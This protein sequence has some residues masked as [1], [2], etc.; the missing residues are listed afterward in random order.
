MNV[1]ILPWLMKLVDFMP[2]IMDGYPFELAK[3]KN[4]SKIKASVKSCGGPFISGG[5][6]NAKSC[7]AYCEFYNYNANSPVIEGY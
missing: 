6:I 1:N 3:V 5:R 2:T 4:F 7:K